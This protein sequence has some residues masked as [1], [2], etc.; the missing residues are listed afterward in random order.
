MSE[1][2]GGNII[3]SGAGESLSRES[4]KKIAEATKVDPSKPIKKETAPKED[5]HVTGEKKIENKRLA[6]AAGALGGMALTEFLEDL[7][8]N[9]A[10]G[11]LK[12]IADKAVTRTTKEQKGERIDPDEDRAFQEIQK[13]LVKEAGKPRTDEIDALIVTRNNLV[14]FANRIGILDGIKQKVE[15]IQT[16]GTYNYEKAGEEIKAIN[17]HRYEDEAK[18]LEGYNDE[19]T[20]VITEWKDG[21]VRQMSLSWFKALKELDPDKYENFKNHH[22]ALEREVEILG[23]GSPP[24]YVDTLAAEQL[25]KDMVTKE[26]VQQPQP[27]GQ[28]ENNPLKEFFPTRELQR[29]KFIENEDGGTLDINA[30]IGLMT[31][32]LP[33]DEKELMEIRFE[34]AKARSVKQSAGDPKDLLPNPHMKGLKNSEMETL[35]S[36]SKV[37]EVVAMYTHFATTVDLSNGYKDFSQLLNTFEVYREGQKVVGIRNLLDIESTDELGEFRK[38]FRN[39]IKDKFSL[40]DK[41]VIDVEQIAYNLFYMSDVAEWANTNYE[42]GIGRNDKTTG[43]VANGARRDLLHMRERAVDDNALKDGTWP[44]NAWGKQLKRFKNNLSSIRMIL[45]VSISSVA[46]SFFHHYELKWPNGSSENLYDFFNREG[47]ELLKENKETIRTLPFKSQPGNAPYHSYYSRMGNQ[48]LIYNIVDTGAIPNDKTVDEFVTAANKLNLSDQFKRD[49]VDLI[50]DRERK[51]LRPSKKS[52]REWKDPFYM[53]GYKVYLK[54]KY[55]F[56]LN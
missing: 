24:T 15:E 48:I 29:K 8:A 37:K 44:N 4:I 12:G 1:T 51:W 33:E 5:R 41:E 47:E 46:K 40:S 52:L 56:L 21:V 20:G 26:Q 45:P 54:E 25:K 10:K 53:G 2:E 49:L 14:E 19:L 42:G 11:V 35:Y 22:E 7:A 23:W 16:S 6:A 31:E 3:V 39:Y 36:H 27:Q 18:G 17:T 50:E 28:T 9:K 55:P 43:N 30:Q 34:L 13:T 32:G 38:K